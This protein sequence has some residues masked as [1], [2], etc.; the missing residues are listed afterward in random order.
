MREFFGWTKNS[1]M[2]ATYVHLSGRDIDEDLLKHYGI[3]P[4]EEEAKTESPLKPKQCPRCKFTNPA[5]SKFCAH[6]SLPLTVET[7]FKIK[8]AE[9]IEEKFV[10]YIIN[11]APEIAERALKETGAIKSLEKYVTGSSA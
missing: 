7:A 11:H 1:D 10:E 4:A 9:H 3:K 5:G 8:E 2:P 6:C